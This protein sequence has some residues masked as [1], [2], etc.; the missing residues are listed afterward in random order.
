MFYFLPIASCLGTGNTEKSLVL[1]S[2]L[3][4]QVFTDISEIPLGPPPTWIVPALSSCPHRRCVPASG[5]FRQS[6]SP[7][8]ATHPSML[9][10]GKQKVPGQDHI[11]WEKYSNPTVWLLLVMVIPF[12]V[13]ALILHLF[14]KRFF[15][16][17]VEPS[18]WSLRKKKR[19]REQIEDLH[20]LKCCYPQVW[21]TL[22]DVL[23]NWPRIYVWMVPV[24]CYA[25]TCPYS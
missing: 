3:S 12:L 5:S 13:K 23:Y 21:V 7:M 24:A 20:S 4:I 2:A 10:Q 18:K 16:L 11:G 19:E 9:L 25:S 1:S 14:L 8:R 17:Q 22:K 6:R 15:V